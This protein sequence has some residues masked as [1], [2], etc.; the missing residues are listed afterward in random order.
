MLRYLS[1][2]MVASVIVRCYSIMSLFHSFFFS[3]RFLSFSR[4]VAVLSII[5]CMTVCHGYAQSGSLLQSGP[6]VG[7]ADYRQVMLWVQTTQPASVQFEYWETTV[8]TKRFTTGIVQTTTQD[9]HIAQIAITPLEPGRKYTYRLRINGQQIDRTYPLEFQTLPLWQFRTAPPNFTMAVGSCVYVNEP[10]YDRPGRGYGDAY[11]IFTTIHAKRPDL[12]LWL[13]D[14]TYFREIDWN[15]RNGMIHRYTHTRSLPEMQALL[16][17]THSYAI[18]DDHEY[19]NN[20][21]DRS[22]WMKHTSLEIFKLFWAN[23]NYGV[24]NS[25]GVTGRFEWGDAEFFM[26]DDRWNKSPNDRI[27]GKRELLGERQ[28]EWLIDALKSSRATF[29]FVAV[30]GQVINPAAVFEN[31]STYPEEYNRLLTTITAEKINGVIFLS[32]DRHHTELSKLERPGTY[33]LLDFTISPLTAGTSNAAE[34]EVN[35]TRVSGTLVAGKRNFALFSFEG[36]QNDRRAICT[37]YDNTGVKLWEY[38]VKAKDLG[39]SNR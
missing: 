22:F 19:G 7:Y 36:V 33:A 24:S 38:T 30:G 28:M 29:K 17:S 15:T 8:A 26:M 9:A 11:N 23:P 4:V 5:S 10:Q 34:K 31:Y 3:M 20:D 18:W 32:G 14:N 25:G 2:S 12:M 6:M 39:W 1:N 13:G 37:V 21:A 27:T 16:G 35:T